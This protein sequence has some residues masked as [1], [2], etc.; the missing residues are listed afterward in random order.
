M[1]GLCLAAVFAMSAMTFAVASPAQASCNEECHK[2]KEEEKQ[3][4]KEQKEQEKAKKEGEEGKYGI[5]TWGQYKYCP[6]E[7]PES[8]F[9]YA[10]ITEGGRQGGFFE[11]GGVKVPLNKP[12]VL[13]GGYK[14]VELEGEIEELQLLPANGAASLEAPELAVTGGIGLFN[15]QLQKDE[16][17]PAALVE[18]WNEAKKNHETGVYVKIEL[19]GTE[20]FEEPTVGSGCLNTTNLLSEKGTA[21]K[22]PL[23]VAVTAP[24]L[25]KLGSGP[26]SIGSDEHPIHINLTAAGPGTPGRLEHN[27]PF[28]QVVFRK[29]RL[30]DVGWTIEKASAPS[31]C[32][33]AYA[34]YIDASLDQVLEVNT[35]GK[36]GIVVLKGSLFT[37]KRFNGI[38]TEGVASGEL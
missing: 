15:K 11:Y 29:S 8:Q 30:A 14:E 24:W 34:P 26:C 19:A 35:A 21:F 4:A 33:G 9:C 36:T 28:T 5:H 13:Q 6:W 27:P 2:L 37:A 7:N 25:E 17:W 20:C 3:K 18:S 16:Q 10:G 23:K 38:L 32:G 1:V 31:G 12:I 22:L